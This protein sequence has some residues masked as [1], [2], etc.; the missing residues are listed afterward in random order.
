V[1]EVEGK[2]FE[3]VL[4]TTITVLAVR[5]YLESYLILVLVPISW[6]LQAVDFHTE[7]TVR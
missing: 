5:A 7:E 4:I 2:V 3:R 6:M 1:G